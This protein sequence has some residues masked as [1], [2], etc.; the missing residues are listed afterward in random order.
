M[1][2][3]GEHGVFT[4][5]GGVLHRIVDEP[6]AEPGAERDVIRAATPL[7]SLRGRPGARQAGITRTLRHITRTAR[8]SDGVNESGR[9]YRVDKR[10]LFRPFKTVRRE[11]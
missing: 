11:N 1:V 6:T 9:H 10:R 7:P 3:H 2:V 4:A 5:D 8:A